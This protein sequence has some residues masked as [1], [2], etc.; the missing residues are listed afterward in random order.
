MG[1]LIGID[2]GEKRTG[3]AHTDHSKIIATGLKSILTK[4]VIKFLKA[5]FEKVEVEMLIIGKPIQRDGKPSNIEEKIKDFVKK[6]KINFP[7]VK[8]DRYD[9]RYTSVIA[10][11]LINELGVKRK[12]RRDKGIIDKISATLI[13][14]SYLEYKK[15][16]L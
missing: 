8:I 15:N 3:L 5:Y 4:D 7:E 13:L 14:Q 11:N 1:C 2:Y 16:K 12:V 6:I 9:E 10:K